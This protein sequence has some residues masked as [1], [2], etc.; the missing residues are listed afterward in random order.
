GGRI[1]RLYRDRVSRVNEECLD[2]GVAY[3]RH[4]PRLWDQ[5]I[6]AHRRSVRD[7][8]LETTAALVAHHGLRSV[9]MSQIAEET[10]IGRATL[11][12]YSPDVDAILVAWHDRLVT[13][14]L[15]QLAAVA[16]QPG[17]AGERLAAVL[18]AYAFIVYERQHYGAEF[19]ALVHRGEQLAGAQRQLTG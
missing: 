6:E 14:D 18:Q 9:T 7:A 19:A 4:V 2:R 16:A 11:Y 10:G 3:S 15:A 13:R 1:H 5:T 12:K 17:D 8:I